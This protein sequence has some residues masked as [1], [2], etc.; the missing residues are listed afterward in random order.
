MRLIA[1]TWAF[2]PPKF[3]PSSRLHRRRVHA[4]AS[5]DGDLRRTTA[6][7]RRQGDASC[8][9]TRQS[10]SG[11]VVVS[12][13]RPTCPTM[14]I[15]ENVLMSDMARRPVVSLVPRAMMRIEARAALGRL[16]IDARSGHQG[17]PAPRSP[18]CSL[19]KLLAL[20][21]SAPACLC[22]TSPIP[23]CRVARAASV[24]RRAPVARGRHDGGPCFSPLARGAQ[25]RRSLRHDHARRPPRS[26]RWT[27]RTCP[28]QRLDP[29]DDSEFLGACPLARDW[30]ALRR[31]Y[32][33]VLSVT[34][35]SRRRGFDC[36]SL[37]VHGG[38]NLWRRR[39]AVRARTVLAGRC[40]ASARAR[41]G[42]RSTAR[43]YPPMR[44]PPSAAAWP[45][46]PPT[47]A[48]SRRP[49]R[50]DGRRRWRLGVAQSLLRRRPVPA[51]R[52]SVRGARAS[53]A[54][55]R[56]NR[57]PRE[58]RR[59][60][61]RR[62]AEDVLGRSLVARPRML[63]LRGPTRIDIARQ[64]PDLQILRGIAGEGVAIVFGTSR[65]RSFLM[66]AERVFL[67]TQ[68]IS[69]SSPGKP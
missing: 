56:A 42:W 44:S 21:A 30:R 16:R 45:S 27:T 6:P 15:A 31:K 40:S 23:L 66:N 60:F 52:P 10:R 59:P 1:S 62:S 20:S 4:H 49:S 19:S 5:L 36:L 69:A 34:G 63:I 47:G 46:C 26:R 65:C 50:H 53:S 68:H 39:P 28:E 55:R 51:R 33:M 14:T 58:A 22:T 8:F 11:I 29:V 2:R 67:A 12:R 17:K 7:C 3:T 25:P 57:P 24:R 37:E 18:R 43:R 32:P 38:E 48:R 13:A 35:P 41:A 9:A 61:G 54:A 64:G